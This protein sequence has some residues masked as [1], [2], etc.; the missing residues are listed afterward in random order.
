MVVCIIY[1]N[2]NATASGM[3]PEL[4]K[5]LDDAMAIQVPGFQFTPAFRNGRWDGKHH[6]FNR[7]TKMFPTGLLGEVIDFLRIKGCRV[8]IKDARPL[9]FDI[10]LPDNYSL[11]LGEGI[12]EREYQVEAVKKGIKLGRGIFNI[13][14]NGGKTEIACGIIKEIMPYLSDNKLFVF[15]T[16]RQ[17]LFNQTHKRLENR[18]GVSV[19]K[20]SAD[21]V[22]VQPVTVAMIPS[23]YAWLESAK[24]TERKYKGQKIQLT[25]EQRQSNKQKSDMVKWVLEN[26]VGFI[27]DE[28]HHAPSEQWYDILKTTRN[29]YWRF[30]LTGTVDAQENP[31]G[32]K[33]LFA[34][35]GGILTK[36]SNKYLIDQGYSAKPVVYVTPVVKPYLYD[37][38]YRDAYKKGIEDSTYRNGILSGQVKSEYDKGF[39]SLIIVNHKGHGNHIL[40]ELKKLG[41]TAEFTHSG[42]NKKY[43]QWII[44]AM[45]AREARVVIATPLFDEGLDVDD[46]HAVFLAAAGKSFIQLMQRIGRGLRKKKDTDNVLRVYDYLDY[47]HDYLV[48]HTITRYDYYLAEGF[49]VVKLEVGQYV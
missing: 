5:A 19:G 2:I 30:G 48:D 44:D 4:S 23:M 35:T 39:S 43:R 15:F 27:G 18:L 16:H 7:G 25:K 42:K 34:I 10:Q 13:A 31:I 33:R 41:I 29:A 11:D 3:T 40:V 20:F 8:M 26:T 17:E 21:G 12:Q 24:K 32:V 46:I 45:K 9:K 36:V 47:M 14:T 38:T 37:E 49:E 22:D 1:D 28:I 6:F